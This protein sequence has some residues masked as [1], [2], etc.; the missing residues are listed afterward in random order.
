MVMVALDA[1]MNR[2]LSLVQIGVRQKQK[3][4]DSSTIATC[5]ILTPCITNRV[6]TRQMIALD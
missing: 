5:L 2:L 1:A 3:A 6:I 4:G